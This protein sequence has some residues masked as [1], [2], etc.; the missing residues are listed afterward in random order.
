MPSQEPSKSSP[1][2]DE[3]MHLY[4]AWAQVLGVEGQR[5]TAQQL[6]WEDLAQ[7]GS[8]RTPLVRVNAQG[9]IDPLAVVYN[10]GKRAVYLHIQESIRRA[11][12]PEAPKTVTVIKE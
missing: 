5:S 7:I 1:A 3:K 12:Q 11:T 6:V 4:R 9:N 8:E 10:D 2:Q